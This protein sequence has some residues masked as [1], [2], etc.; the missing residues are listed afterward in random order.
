MTPPPARPISVKNTSPSPTPTVHGAGGSHRALFLGSGR[1]K[2]EGRPA[3]S[4]GRRG[5]GGAVP[6][7]PLRVPGWDPSRPSALSPVPPLR[8]GSP[9][10]PA[11]PGQGPSSCTSSS[12]GLSSAVTLHGFSV[13]GLALSLPAR[14]SDSR[15]GGRGLACPLASRNVAQGP[16]HEPPSDVGQRHN[17]NIN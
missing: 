6:C 17:L 3:G 9:R 2:A 8:S 13:F 12:R 14:I 4:R 11:G 5:N 15:E 16:V 7:P 1:W 10:V